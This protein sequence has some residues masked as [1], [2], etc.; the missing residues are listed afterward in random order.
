IRIAPSFPALAEVT[1]AMEAVATCV[2]LAAAE[3]LLA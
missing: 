1:G 3:K 2:R